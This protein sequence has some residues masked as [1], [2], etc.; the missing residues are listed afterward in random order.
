[1]AFYV[2]LTLATATIAALA[3]AVW[4]KTRQVAFLLG[5]AF[6][7]YWSL[8]GGW[9]IVNRGL[10]SDRSYRFEYMFYK[11]FPVYLDPDY[12]WALVLYSGFVIIVQLVVLRVAEP[13][14]AL[15]VPDSPIYISH[16][17]LLAMCAAFLAGAYFIAW[18]FVAASVSAGRSAYGA[19]GRGADPPL[20]SFYQ[21]FHEM[22][23]VVLLLGVSVL[24]SG[25]H[26]RF[27]AS[28]SRAYLPGYAVLGLALLVLTLAMGRRSML[29]FGGIAAALF[30]LANAVRPRKAL[31]A[32][33]LACAIL[34]LVLL[35]VLRG[36]AAQREF[37]DQG[38]IGK[39]RYMA[40]ETLT[41]D[42]EAFAA[43]ASLYGVLQKHVPL[44][45]GTSFVWL[46]LSVVPG[47][48]R[49]NLV[50]TGYDHYAFHVG[51][52]ADQGFTIHHATGWY[53]NFGVAG[54][55][56][57][58]VVLGAAWAMAF[59]AFLHCYRRRSQVAR[60]FSALAFWT[61]TAYLPILIRSGVEAYKGA[62]A[63]SVVIPALVVVFA[64]VELGRVANRVRLVP[65]L[66][67]RPVEWSGA[68]GAQHTRRPV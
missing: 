2:V 57:G 27:V 29:A 62:I 45:Y 15:R 4:R 43:H 44:T 41:Q 66:P 5:F 63:E 50:P 35:G 26:S 3:V 33:G 54:L 60:V 36:V 52:S 42:V 11:L 18:D 37:S 58:A 53:L 24:F 10:G 9:L 17:K 25:R 59:N 40:G 32:G 13:A 28:G 30:Y 21:L 65:L 55:V 22:A 48:L 39:I 12:L 38:V 51:A 20:M 56:L 8:Y 7:Y 47:V 67:S 1:M 68:L 61:F 49:P 34:S 6:L 14:T 64:S 23:A 46:A 31:V 16:G 19:L